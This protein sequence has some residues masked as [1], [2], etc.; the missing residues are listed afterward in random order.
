M[1]N[2]PARKTS[3]AADSIRER[4]LREQL[5][6]AVNVNL[7]NTVRQGVENI[8]ELTDRAVTELEKRGIVGVEKLA[9]GLADFTKRLLIRGI[10]K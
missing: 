7:V 3:A 2:N 4:P 8:D 9:H 10:S 6:T 1:P 5:Q